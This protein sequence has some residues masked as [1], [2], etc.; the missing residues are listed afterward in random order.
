MLFLTQY[1]LNFLWI[2]CHFI[3]FK[4]FEI[5]TF[6]ILHVRPTF[7]D[8]PVWQFQST[9]CKFLLHAESIFY[10]KVQCSLLLGGGIHEDHA[11]C[12]YYIF[13]SFIWET[14]L[15]WTCDYLL[16]VLFT[17]DIS[18]LIW[19]Y[20]FCSF[21]KL[22]WVELVI[23]FTGIV[24]LRILSLNLTGLSFIFIL[25]SQVFRGSCDEFRH[26]KSCD[27]RSH[28][29]RV[30]RPDSET[31]DLHYRQSQWQDHPLSTHATDGLRVL[32]QV[33][34]RYRVKRFLQFYL[35]F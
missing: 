24:Y 22:V 19:R 35:W 13:C 20:I 34:N 28:E 27:T 23:I 4:M 6:P 32:A 7:A 25:L 8:S 15:S 9:S 30:T 2:F 21:K 31:E 11:S 10:Q 14:G 33:M 3:D 1:V 26:F 5:K 29:G 16:Q 18:L 17:K 12:K